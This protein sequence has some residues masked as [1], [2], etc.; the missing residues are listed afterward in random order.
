M[1]G[2]L[3]IGAWSSRLGGSGQGGTKHGRS[4]GE[5]IRVELLR[6]GEVP[7]I[8]LPKI[9]I[10]YWLFREIWITLRDATVAW[11]RDN[12]YQLAAALAFYTTFSLAPA[13]VVGVA[14]AG[15][16]IGRAAA[17][18]QLAGLLQQYMGPQAQ[19]FLLTVLESSQ[20]QMTGQTATLIGIGTML[21]GTTI[22]FVE[23]KSALNH[24][25][26]VRPSSS[27]SIWQWV[28]TR[29]ISFLLVLGIGAFLVL[30][31]VTSTVLAVISE[32][33]S[34][35]ITIPTGFLQTINVLVSF[36]MVTILFAFM[37]RSL[38]DGEIAWKDM[39]I[40]SAITSLLFTIGKW[41]LAMY[42]ASSVL[43]SVYGAAGSLVMIL[44]W[45]YYSAMVVLFGAELTQVYAKRYGSGI[46]PP[47]WG[48][49]DGKPQD[50]AA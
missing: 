32:F 7:L 46:G 11:H 16:I 4:C 2:G 14:V 6:R 29:L 12:A 18:T 41:I 42:L 17:Q 25:W 26:N 48:R 5:S 28:R 49:D 27:L 40:G 39:V 34:H 19:S 3:L 31:L 21:F 38:P 37:Y 33:F 36:F 10:P 50:A 9:T 30:S 35:S 23:L 47:K 1:F 44:V 45:V 43:R 15:A 8:S 22:V 20:G 13:L 24:I